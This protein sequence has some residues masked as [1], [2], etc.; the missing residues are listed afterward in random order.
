MNRSVIFLAAI[1]LTLAAASKAGSQWQ[2]GN[3][4]L[5]TN[6][7]NFQ[8]GDRLKVEVLALKSISEPFYTQV[9]Y[10]FKEE[11]RVED[12]KGNKST[13]HEERVRT[14]KP[15]PALEGLEEFRSLTLD[16]T[17]NFGE[18]SPEGAYTVE[19]AVF[20]SYTKE[21]VAVLRSCIWYGDAKPSGKVCA[22]Y[23]RSLRWTYTD[24]WVS[25]DG[26]FSESGRYSVALLSGDKV[27]RYFDGG[28]FTRGETELS[29][30]SQEL[31]ALAGQTFD[32][33]IHDHAQNYS[34]TLMRVRLPAAP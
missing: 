18:A 15:G 27:V 17:F 19:V 7:N 11:V 10:R 8:S 23:P 34:S 5:R 2:A 28:V 3:L 22:L 1:V 21:R 26:T 20:S 25:F 16:D 29:V 32:V 12:K 33:L 4:A 13:K 30:A 6:G 24:E 31:K 14:R 9:S